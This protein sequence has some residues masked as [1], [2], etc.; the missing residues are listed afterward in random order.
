M[1]NVWKVQTV[2]LY[3]KLSHDHFSVISSDPEKLKAL[4]VT[5]VLNCACG[6]K[7]NMINTTQEFFDESGIKFHGIRATDIMTYKMAPHFHAAADFI[8][9]ALTS[10]GK[11][12]HCAI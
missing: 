12:K 5:H 7:F 1:K 8:N 10:E 4:G 11:I 6:E 9:D 3:Q 2:R